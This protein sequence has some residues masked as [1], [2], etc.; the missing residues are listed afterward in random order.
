MLSHRRGFTLIELLVV[1]AIIAILIGLLLPAVQKVRESAARA[2][3]QNNLK[4]IGLGLNNFHS[5]YGVFPPGAVAST[6]ALISQSHLKRAGVSVFNVNHSWTP[7]ILSYIEQ[8]NVYKQY[9]M[10]KSWNA[11]VNRPIIT[12]PIK[13]FMCPSVPGGDSRMCITSSGAVQNPPTDYAPNNA[14]AA[15]L[16][17]AGY[18]DVASD[19]TGILAVN[20]C[21]SI[22]EVRDGASNTFLISEDAGRPDRWQAGQLIAANG[23]LDGGWADRNNEYITHGYTTDGTAHP[24]PCHT[25]CTNNNEVYSFHL[26]GAN[27]VL[28]DGSVKFISSSM[29]IRLFVKFITRQGDD[30]VV[31]DN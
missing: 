11:T 25:N 31:Q 30:I 4:Q 29:D 9:T 3:C 7:F 20:R 5:T 2:K 24:G 6:T 22:P 17:T 21:Y 8:D 28:A 13:I 26:G 23:Q 27:H 12:T 10:G 1:I 19:R 16:E 15:A 14:Y 18:V